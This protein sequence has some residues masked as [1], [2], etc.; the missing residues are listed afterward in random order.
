MLVDSRSIHNF[1]VLTLAKRLKCNSQ[2]ITGVIV[3]VANE[4]VLK[5]YEVC[6]KVSWES[7]GFV[8]DTYFLVLPLRGCDMVL[9]V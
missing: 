7:Q 6:K 9:G 3:T 4:E 2:G 5:A 1:M 8:Q